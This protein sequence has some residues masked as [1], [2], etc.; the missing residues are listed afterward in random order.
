ME[1]VRSLSTTNV[2]NSNF[3]YYGKIHITNFTILTILGVQFRDVK[4]IHNAV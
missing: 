1:H 2:V 4:Y 3:F